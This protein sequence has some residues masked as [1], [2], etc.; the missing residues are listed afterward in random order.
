M[1]AL[2]KYSTPNAKALYPWNNGWG[3][4]AEGYSSASLTFLLYTSSISHRSHR[5]GHAR[6]AECYMPTVVPS[7]YEPQ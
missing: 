6:C 5:C 3:N 4:F 1:R 7:Q 2:K